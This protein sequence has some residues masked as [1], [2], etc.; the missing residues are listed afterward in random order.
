M[1][2]VLDELRGERLP[3]PNVGDFVRFQFKR[4]QVAGRVGAK[5]GT[6]LRV[7]FF[8][9]STKNPRSSWVAIKDATIVPR[10]IIPGM[11]KSK[12]VSSASSKN[13]KLNDKTPRI[14]SDGHVVALHASN[15]SPANSRRYKYTTEF[16]ESTINLTE[17]FSEPPETVTPTSARIKGLDNGDHPLSSDTEFESSKG[18][19]DTW[20]LEPTVRSSTIAS[21]RT[22]DADRHRSPEM[23]R[24][25]SIDLRGNLK[26]IESRTNGISER[27]TKSSSVVVP[28]LQASD[29]STSKEEIS[30]SV[31][32]AIF[33]ATAVMSKNVE[34]RNLPDFDSVPSPQLP[35][36]TGV[37]P[38]LSPATAAPLDTNMNVMP[39]VSAPGPSD[40]TVESDKESRSAKLKNK[41][42]CDLTLADALAYFQRVKGKLQS[43]R[44]AYTEF[45]KVMRDMKERK[46]ETSDI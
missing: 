25:K 1:P 20:R 4:Q 14:C 42:K 13:I 35:S 8:F 33:Y 30:K 10:P 23:S 36:A 12:T 38:K 7:H 24:M 26:S 32:A 41:A 21:I 45:L 29:S 37:L 18:V 44:H 39:Q 31:E 15:D 28:R 5:N 6:H 17:A 19:G 22:S 34:S 2:Q 9:R 3:V 40:S 27:D 11:T 43:D 46:T 16:P